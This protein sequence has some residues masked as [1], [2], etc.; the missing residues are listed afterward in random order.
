MVNPLANIVFFFRLNSLAKRKKFWQNKKV[1]WLNVMIKKK[2]IENKKGKN[3]E[4]FNR[5]SRSIYLQFIPL[6]Q[7]KKKI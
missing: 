7:T 2:K 5:L 4:I 3:R 1:D 6:Q